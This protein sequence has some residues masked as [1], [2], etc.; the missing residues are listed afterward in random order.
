MAGEEYRSSLDYV[1]NEKQP[2]TGHFYK[3][4]GYFMKRGMYDGLG[5]GREEGRR[6]VAQ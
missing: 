1:K 3:A 2:E 5:R 4:H 6:G